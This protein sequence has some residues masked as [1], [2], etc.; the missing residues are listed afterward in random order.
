MESWLASNLIQSSYLSLG[1]DGITATT[2]LSK[3]KLSF[4]KMYGEDFKRVHSCVHACV[5]ACNQNEEYFQS[6]MRK[7]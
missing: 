3:G 2:M 6:Q 1:N 4:L 5:R 7:G